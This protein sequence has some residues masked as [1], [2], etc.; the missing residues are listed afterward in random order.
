MTKYRVQQIVRV[1]VVVRVEAEDVDE[2]IIAAEEEIYSHIPKDGPTTWV[3]GF[4]DDSEQA[5]VETEGEEDLTPGDI[6]YKI[7]EIEGKL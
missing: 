1:L 7:L 5:M 6:G 4:E 3:L 2:A